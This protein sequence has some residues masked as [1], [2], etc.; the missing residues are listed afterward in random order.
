MSS[1]HLPTTNQG[2][3][4]LPHE[5]QNA[6]PRTNFAHSHM[7]DGSIPGMGGIY[8][9]SASAETLHYIKTLMYLFFKHFL[10]C[11]VGATL[12]AL[13]LCCHVRCNPWGIETLFCIAMLGATLG[14]ETLFCVAVLG[15]TLG[16]LVL[17]CRV[18]CNPWGISSVLP[19]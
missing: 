1:L 3:Y 13:V 10:C 7:N 11:H 18:R 8:S 14:I 4:E 5:A 16:A 19:C 17:C 9:V 12:G 2:P 6:C 15:A